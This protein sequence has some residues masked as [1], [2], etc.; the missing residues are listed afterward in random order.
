MTPNDQTGI[1]HDHDDSHDHKYN[2]VVNGRAKVWHSDQISFDQIVTLAYPVPPYGENTLFSV[3]YRKGHG[4]KPEG[5]LAAG[6]TVRVK[7]GMIFDVTATDK[8]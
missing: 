6:E 7:E 5:I 1:G 2:I 8:S 3:T 4:H